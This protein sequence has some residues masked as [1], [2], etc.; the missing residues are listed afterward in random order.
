VKLLC[1]NDFNEASISG[2]AESDSEYF[3]FSIDRDNQLRILGRFPKM[4][5]PSYR[6]FVL[7][8]GKFD[9]YSFFLKKKITIPALDF[10][11][12]KRLYHDTPALRVWS[13][14]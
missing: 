12:L 7:I 9:A 8:C 10:Q 11:I 13:P 1:I 14:K 3:S 6:R 4:N 5:Y 2:Y